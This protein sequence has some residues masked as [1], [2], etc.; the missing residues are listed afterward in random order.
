M[1]QPWAW[2]IAHGDK[3]IENRSRN[4]AAGTVC[5]HCRDDDGSYLPWPCPTAHALALA[6]LFR[7]K[8]T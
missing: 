2:A 1:R 8:E 3:D 7:F 4:I 6:G 5:D